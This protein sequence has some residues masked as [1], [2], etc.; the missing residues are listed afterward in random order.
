MRDAV[1]RSSTS[2]RQLRRDSAATSLTAATAPATS[3]TRRPV[4]PGRMISGIDPSG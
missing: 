1:K 4:R 3:S 2:S